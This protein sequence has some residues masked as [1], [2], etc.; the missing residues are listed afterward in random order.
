ML[1]C[2][3]YV[4]TLLVQHFI[5]EVGHLEGVTAIQPVLGRLRTCLRYVII[6]E[7]HSVP[8][9]ILLLERLEVQL[10][11]DDVIS[12]GQV[13]LLPTFGLVSTLS[14]AVLCAEVTWV[15]LRWL[16]VYVSRCMLL[17]LETRG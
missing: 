10:A 9:P 6:V 11:I 15:H 1:L 5:F 13:A 17:R 16:H 4:Q 14:L 12:I 3:P 7:I 2:V 8:V